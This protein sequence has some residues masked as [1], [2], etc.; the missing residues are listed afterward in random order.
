MEGNIIMLSLGVIMVLLG[1]ANLKG[2]ISTVHWYNRHR[3]TEEDVPKYGKFMGLGS[4]TIG[5]SVI[6]TAVLM[7]I[8]NN[9]IFYY[10]SV[11]GIIAGIALMLYAQIKF[12][13]GIF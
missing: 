12:N 10:I 3:V 2:N 1:I 5:F 7:M 6:L 9:E 13:K 8:F 11:A 4:I